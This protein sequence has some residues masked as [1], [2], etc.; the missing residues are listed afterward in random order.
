MRI[1]DEKWENAFEEDNEVIKIPND[2]LISEE[3]LITKIF[4]ETIDSEDDSIKN[5]VILAPKQED[6]LEL[7]NKILQ[8]E[9]SES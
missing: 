9:Q 7:N 8:R 6:V 3:E 5:N 1:E 2:M 4:G